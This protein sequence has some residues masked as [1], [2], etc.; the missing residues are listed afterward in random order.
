MDDGQMGSAETSGGLSAVQ[1]AE[2]RSRLTLPL[3]EIPARYFYDDRGS[4]LFEQIT[5]LPEYY[6]TRTERH[7][8]TLFASQIIER[9][10]PDTLS[11]LGSGS[12][13]K[14]GLLIDAGRVGGHLKQVTFLDV[15]WGMVQSARAAVESEFPGLQTEGIEGDFLR[16]LDL[17]KS[18]SRQLLILFGGTIGNLHPDGELGE[19]LARVAAVMGPEDGFLVGI[20]LVK[21]PGVLEAAYN[22]SQGVTAEFNRNI[23][24]NLSFML[25][26]NIPVEAFQHRAFFDTHR[27]WIEMRLRATRDLRLD[28]G[29]LDLVLKLSDGDEIRT[30][31]SCKYTRD[32]LETHCE[33]AGLKLSDWYA[34]DQER[35]ALALLCRSGSR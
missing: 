5:E 32:M 18:A 22:D 6:Q 10:Q 17:L 9:I 35:F 3:P 20:D 12:G 13:S 1:R 15:N 8:L 23:L 30:E 26:A 4:E 31:I 24:Q 19:F 25:G 29:D 11:E 14:I 33:A 27:S 16:D 7:L 34:D 21:D 2:L 28:L